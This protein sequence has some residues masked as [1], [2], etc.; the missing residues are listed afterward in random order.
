M[1]ELC[2][3][4]KHGVDAMSGVMGRAMGRAMGGAMGGV[5]QS[6]YGALLRD[7]LW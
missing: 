5:V 3:L 4:R 7:N 1:C 2:E 6:N